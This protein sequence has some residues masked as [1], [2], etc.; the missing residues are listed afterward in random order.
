MLGIAFHAAYLPQ[1]VAQHV[2]DLAI[3]GAQIVI[4]PALQRGQQSGIEPHEKRFALRHDLLID[5]AGVDDR[6]SI[7]I[8][9]Q[10]DQQVAHHRCLTILI[11]RDHGTLGEH[12]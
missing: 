2:L 11:Q 1:S 10:H 8:G 4:R 7:L 3:Q 5:R 9:A 12:L 6:L